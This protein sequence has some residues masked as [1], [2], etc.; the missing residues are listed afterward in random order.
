MERVEEFGGKENFLSEMIELRQFITQQFTPRADL[1]LKHFF[2]CI[3]ML[4]ITDNLMT[5]S[6]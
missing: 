5:N 4:F 3:M 6:A 2:S 1:L